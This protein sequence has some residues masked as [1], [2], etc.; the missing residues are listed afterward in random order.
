M[1]GDAGLQTQV[2]PLDL[3]VMLSRLDAGNFTMAI[4]QLPELTEP[5]MLSWFFHPRGIPGEGEDGRNRARYRSARAGELLDHAAASFDLEVRKRLYGE[6][7]HL[8]MDD[9]PVIPL[10]HEDQMAV[11]ATRVVGFRPTAAGHWDSLVNTEL[12]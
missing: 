5:N 10:W 2:I 6:L 4:L 8:M 3:G 7:A 11:A 1:L 9:M 12:R